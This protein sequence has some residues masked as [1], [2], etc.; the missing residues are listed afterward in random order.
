MIILICTRC[1]Q[2]FS[3]HADGSARVC[4]CGHAAGFIDNGKVWL[5]SGTKAIGLANS[6][7]IRSF[8][9]EEGYKYIECMSIPTSDLHYYELSINAS[10]PATGTRDSAGHTDVSAR[11]RSLAE[12]SDTSRESTTAATEPSAGHNP[13]TAGGGDASRVGADG[14]S[15][16]AP[17]SRLT[18]RNFFPFTRGQHADPGDLSAGGGTSAS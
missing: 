15:A 12:A 4:D 2:A 10:D 11:I 3:A 8:R 9:S 5:S 13:A 14:L 16:E 6:S 18:A 7:L 17:E 1:G